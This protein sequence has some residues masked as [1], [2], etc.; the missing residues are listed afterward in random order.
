MS[1]KIAI[2]YG[3]RPEFLKVFPLIAQFQKNRHDVCIINTG[4]HDSMLTEM[5]TSFGIIP[6]LSL[7]V[8]RKEFTNSTLIAKL[9]KE[10]SAAVHAENV[11][12]IVAQGDTF[13]VLASSMVAF[14][15]QRR[16]YHVEAGLRTSNI[17]L[18][19]PEEY[20]RRVVSIGSDMNF[21]PTERSKSNLLNEGI[22]TEKILL[23]GNTIVDMIEHVLEKEQIEV[24]FEDQ[25]FITA[26]RRENIGEP[27]RKISETVKELAEENPTTQFHWALHPNPQTRRIILDSFG[28]STPSN[29]IF[30][31]PLGYI[32]AIR[33]MAAS[34]ILI[35][36]SGGIQ[37]EA[38]TLQKHVLI[39]R[40]ETERPEVLDRGCGILTGCDRK[41]IKENYYRITES[42]PKFESTQ[43]PFGDGKA[44][45]RIYKEL[46][47][48]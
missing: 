37:E 27:L 41:K 6:N 44:S 30:T 38:P 15:E 35:S 5:E 31:E 39:L 24:A 9:I 2:V 12:R 47:K 46:I 11:D 45:E 42:E 10:L 8:Q 23:T 29:V 22:P 43:N 21:A 34:K 17:R 4:Q 32:E 1:K 28:N 19:F 14:M 26:H 25:V 20:N 13:T 7:C 18:P 36:D 33:K 40:E 48:E 3:T 16:F